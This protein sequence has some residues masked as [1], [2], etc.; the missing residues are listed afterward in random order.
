[1]MAD[2]YNPR[3]EAGELQMGFSLVYI[4]SFSQLGLQSKALFWK[5]K[6]NHHHHQIRR[7][8]E[9]HIRKTPKVMAMTC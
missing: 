8:P 4:V 9:E 5:T 6:L 7:V 3:V 1:M 2:S